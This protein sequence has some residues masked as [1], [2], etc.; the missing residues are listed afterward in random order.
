ML[1]ERSL[2]K[3]ITPELTKAIEETF[4]QD[5]DANQSEA[6]AQTEKPKIDDAAFY[7]L[8]GNV[9]GTIESYTANQIP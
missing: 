3:V 9:A 1:T 4:P 7:G 5:N 2:E 8:A 6:P